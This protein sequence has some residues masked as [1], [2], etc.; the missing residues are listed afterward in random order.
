M[1][2]NRVKH[3]HIVLAFL[4]AVSISS[5]G[6]LDQPVKGDEGHDVV[7]RIWAHSDIQPRSIHEKY[8]YERAIADMLAGVPGIQMAI[9]A[10]DLV[11][12]RDGAAEYHRWLVEQRRRSGIAYWFEIAGNHDQNDIDSYIKYTGKPLHYAVSMGNMLFIFLS[13]EVR[14]AVTDISDEAFEWWRSL[15]AGNQDKILIT[16]THGALHG[17]GLLCTINS[18]MRIAGSRRFSGVLREY[19]VDLWLSGHSHLPSILAGN[20]TRPSDL[21]TLFVDISSIHKSRFS[22]IESYLLQIKSGSDRMDI[23]LRD[24]EA[25]RFIGSRSVVLKL[26]TALRWDGSGPRIVSSCCGR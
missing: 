9:V 19:P 15:V 23:M 18:T 16:I 17:S 11:H 13:D 12:R 20:I 1:V 22:P 26:R 7:L 21:G 4:G 14:S 3:L 6:S 10:G 8:H 2:Y 25:G 5:C 24:H